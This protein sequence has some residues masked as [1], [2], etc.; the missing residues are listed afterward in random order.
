MKLVPWF[1][2]GVVY[3]QD[4]WGND[5]PVAER[6]GPRPYGPGGCVPCRGLCRGLTARC[7]V[8]VHADAEAERRR[9]RR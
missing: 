7:E 1:V 6:E 8:R 2:R 4:G 9:G 5:L 3:F